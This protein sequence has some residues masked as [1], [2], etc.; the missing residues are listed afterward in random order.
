[1][2]RAFRQLWLLARNTFVEAVRQKFFHFVLLLGVG[3]VGSAQF[4]RQFDFGASELKFIFDFGFG[5]IWMF[6][7]ILAVVAS[8][9]LFYNEIE[10]RTALTLLA[11]PVY[12]G[13]FVLGKFLGVAALL[14][15]FMALMTSLLAGVLYLREQALMEAGGKVW[16][17]EGA[18]DYQGLVFF[19]VLQWVRLLVVAA[20]TF[21]MVSLSSTYLYAVIVSFLGMMIGQLRYLVQ[22]YGKEEVSVVLGSVLK[23]FSWVFPNL[24]LFNVGEALVLHSAGETLGMGA[25]AQIGGY[26]L[27]YIGVFLVIG[28]WVFRGREL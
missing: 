15:V 22:E 25:V 21:L 9:Q 20:M 12:R 4:F 14:L 24:Q 23:L 28:V 3:L 18:M 1:M 16:A 10:Q 5:G 7:S 11:K 8:V 6:G 2:R 26:G 13:V 19:A 27:L 17:A